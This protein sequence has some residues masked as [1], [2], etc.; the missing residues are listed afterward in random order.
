MGLFSQANTLITYAV[1][2]IPP[3]LAM[4]WFVSGAA[5]GVVLGMLVFLVYKPKDGADGCANTPA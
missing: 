4:K 2:P 5:Q 1:Q 3:G